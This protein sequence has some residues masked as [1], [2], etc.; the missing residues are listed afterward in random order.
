MD[1]IDDG[2]VVTHTSRR[3]PFSSNHEDRTLVTAHEMNEVA[4]A[5]GQDQRVRLVYVGLGQRDVGA[6]PSLMRSNL[7]SLG[8]CGI[9]QRLGATDGHET[10]VCILRWSTTGEDECVQQRGQPRGMDV[11]CI[12]EDLHTAILPPTNNPALRW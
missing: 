4:V 6:L 5:A 1:R 8:P 11:V 7:R 12:D 10:H 3:R 9:C 2:G